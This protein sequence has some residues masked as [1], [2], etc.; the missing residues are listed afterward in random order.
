MLGTFGLFDED[1]DSESFTPGGSSGSGGSSNLF[2]TTMINPHFPQMGM[3]GQ[4][5]GFN[6]MMSMHGGGMMGG[7]FNMGMMGGYP[8][9]PQSPMY[10]YPMYGPGFY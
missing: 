1:D 6:P 8:M 10:P 3:G 4:M 9:M 7:G 5:Q 2:P